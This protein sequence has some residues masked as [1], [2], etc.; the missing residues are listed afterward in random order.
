MAT[1]EL[2]KQLEANLENVI[3]SPN[4]LYKELQRRWQKEESGRNFIVA[5]IALVLSLVGIVATILV[6]IFKG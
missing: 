4:D 2:E 5:V 1:E 3:Y 6:A